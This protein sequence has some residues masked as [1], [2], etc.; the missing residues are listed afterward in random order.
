[1]NS[2]NLQTVIAVN[3]ILKVMHKI[4]AC[5]QVRVQRGVLQWQVRELAPGLLLAQFFAT[6]LAC[7]LHPQD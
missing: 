3:S 1:V 5:L 6:E 4:E 7:T 2:T